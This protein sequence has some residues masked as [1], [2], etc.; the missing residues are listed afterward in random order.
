VGKSSLLNA[1]LSKPLART[2]NTPVRLLLRLRENSLSCRVPCSEQDGALA[3]QTCIVQGRT[4]TINY[5]QAGNVKL[6]DLPGTIIL[7]FFFLLLSLPG[8]ICP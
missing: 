7:Y 3:L 8:E 4:Q 1:L 2:S 6:V 5:Y